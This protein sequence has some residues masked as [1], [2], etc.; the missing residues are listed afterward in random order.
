MNRLTLCLLLL[1]LCLAADDKHVALKAGQTAPA[2]DA[3]TIDGKV[4]HFPADFKGKIVLLDFWATW[5]PDC[6]GYIP[7][8]VDAYTKFKDQNF[9]ILGIS[10][11]EPD[12]AEQVKSFTK[13]NKMPWPEIYEGKNEENSYAKLYGVVGIPHSFLVDA[14]TG[15]IL[16]TGDDAEGDALAPAIDKA[17]KE[18]TPK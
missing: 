4:L 15:K 12:K 16:A 17:L 13:D 7:S 5:C 3:K 14:D 6:I 2:F 9:Q 10:L 18:K 11:D 1:P 8:D